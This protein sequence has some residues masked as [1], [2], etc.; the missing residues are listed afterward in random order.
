MARVAVGIRIDGHRADAQPA[1]GLDDPAGD[2]AAVG[3]QEAVEQTLALDP[4]RPA[5][6]QEGRDALLALGRS[7][8]Q[9]DH[10]D[11]RLRADAAA[12]RHHL[13]ELYQPLGAGPRLP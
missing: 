10:A 6:L 7:A 2:L 8:A 4:G 3:D 5:L 12:L 9:G 13:D 1:A 11:G